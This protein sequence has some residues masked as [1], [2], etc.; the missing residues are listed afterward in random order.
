MVKYSALVPVYVTVSYTSWNH[1]TEPGEQS[2]CL[3]VFNISIKL[4]LLDLLVFK[5]HQQGFRS[6]SVPFH[7]NWPTSKH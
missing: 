2:H 6:G 4:V 1:Y 3:F 5:A 7:G